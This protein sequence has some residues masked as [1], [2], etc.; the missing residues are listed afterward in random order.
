MSRA[1]ERPGELPGDVPDGLLC[2]TGGAE[3]RPGAVNPFASAG[4][5]DAAGLS[6]VD[7]GEVNRCPVVASNE[8]ASY[9]LRVSI[10]RTRNPCDQEIGK[11]HAV[12]A[13][14]G[15]EV[16]P[17]DQTEVGKHR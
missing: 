6:G 11:S 17:L 12:P 13:W 4:A 8:G 7:I 1:G 9:L 14:Q 2:E 5:P 16:R 15:Q 3:V 10:D